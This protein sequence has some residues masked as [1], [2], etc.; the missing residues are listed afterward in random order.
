M[1][2]HYILPTSFL[3]G[4]PAAIG[5]RYRQWENDVASYQP[6]AHG[7]YR[8]FTDWLSIWTTRRKITQ[9][10]THLNLNQSLYMSRGPGIRSHDQN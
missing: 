3:L 7:F 6:V 5:T 2:I 1:N 4:R 9:N 8:S 10:N